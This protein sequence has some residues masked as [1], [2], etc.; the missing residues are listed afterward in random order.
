MPEIL[1]FTGSQAALSGGQKQRV[2]FARA[3][4]RRP[5]LLLLD[6]PFSA[7]DNP[8]RIEMRGF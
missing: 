7:M 4:I 5:N 6:E 2:A 3:L 8:L 1:V